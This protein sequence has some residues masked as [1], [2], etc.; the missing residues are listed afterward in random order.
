MDK[1]NIIYQKDDVTIYWNEKRNC[2]WYKS[3][4]HSSP[5]CMYIH[6]C[7]D[8]ESDEYE[9]IMNFIKERL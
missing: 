8:L 4:E 9:A 3:Q 5:I 2:L 7:F 6:G 1:K